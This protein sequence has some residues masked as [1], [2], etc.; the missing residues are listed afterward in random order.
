MTRK[1]VSFNKTGI[2]QLPNDKPVVYKILTSSGKNNYTGIAQ[3]G[4]IQERLQEH[5]SDGKDSVP[6][7]K[8]QIEQMKSI[9]DAKEKEENIISRTKPKYNE[10]GK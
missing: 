5:L 7:T 10:Q 1:T 6:G 9:D 8:V 4:R 3:R 2:E